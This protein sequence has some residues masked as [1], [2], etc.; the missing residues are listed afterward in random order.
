MK[1]R[2]NDVMAESEARDTSWSQPEIF[3]LNIQRNAERLEQAYSDGRV[4]NTHNAI[5]TIA[6]NLFELNHP[7]GTAEELEDYISQ[8]V[9]KDRLYG[10]WVL[11]SWSGDL[12]RFPEE[13]DYFSMRTDRF[14]N[15]VTREQQMG[16]RE[17][18]IFVAGQSVGSVATLA[19]VKNLGI[20]KLTLSDKA[21]PN[22]SGIG[23]SESSML[24]LGLSKIDGTAKRVSLLDP[25]LTQH[26]IHE[27]I[28]QKTLQYV[29]EVPSLVVD[30]MDDME[31]SA[32]IRDFS[33]RNKIPY[34]TVSD[35][36]DTVVLEVLRHDLDPTLPLYAGKVSHKEAQALLDGVMD[37]VDQQDVF[38]RTIG[39]TNLTPPLIES[40][41]QIG[42]E[43]AGIP[44]KGS[45]ALIAAGMATIACRE[46]LL[47]NKLDTG[48]YS[49]NIG[50]VMG[51]RF[52][53]REWLGAIRG[54]YKGIHR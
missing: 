43:V 30:E 9:F 5:E 33:K 14:R 19:L 41:L 18:H 51:R 31:S 54:Y 23:R 11:Y 39:Y 53:A 50:K 46:A 49:V 47:G 42:I 17:K 2:L 4:R 8:D 35:V 36:D 37:E 6:R 32:A 13:D 24:D 12:V 7:D 1:E 15:L 45:T 21:S 40:T 48:I 16:L 27:G 22:V 20:G 34:I 52:T 38:A 25:F 3:N 44:Q 10:R 26:H 29:E 28:S